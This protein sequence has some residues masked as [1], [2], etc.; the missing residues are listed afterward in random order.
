MEEVLFPVPLVLVVP[1]WE[2]VVFQGHLLAKDFP[3]TYDNI[4]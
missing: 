4:A 2:V 3:L 1:L